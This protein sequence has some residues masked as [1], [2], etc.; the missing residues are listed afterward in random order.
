M[1]MITNTLD[2]SNAPTIINTYDAH[3]IEEAVIHVEVL[4]YSL[5]WLNIVHDTQI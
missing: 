2:R 5:G 4:A 3:A 1:D